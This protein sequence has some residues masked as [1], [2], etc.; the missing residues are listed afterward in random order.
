MSSWY[1]ALDKMRFFNPKVL[2]FILFLHK[3]ICCGYSSEAPQQGVSNEYP[4]VLMEIFFFQ[5]FP[6][7]ST[8]TYVLGTH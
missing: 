5:Y 2:I 6:C 8:K 1:I 3:N 4:H 7:F